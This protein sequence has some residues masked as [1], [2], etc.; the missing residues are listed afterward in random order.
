M[1]ISENDTPGNLAL[2]EQRLRR[3]EFLL[4][5]SSDLDGLPEGIKVPEKSDDTVAARITR[6]EGAL[7]RLRSLTG[8]AGGIV[9]DIEAVC[10]HVVARSRI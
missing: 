5:G 4:T 3:L 7:E 8:P 1:D 9:R 2:Q 10:T 6:L